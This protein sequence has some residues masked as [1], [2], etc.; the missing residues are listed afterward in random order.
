MHTP[1][2]R[3]RW[4]ARLTRDVYD[5]V[6]EKERDNWHFRGWERRLEGSLEIEKMAVNVD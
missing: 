1:S 3:G 4:S 5:K 2:I 6:L